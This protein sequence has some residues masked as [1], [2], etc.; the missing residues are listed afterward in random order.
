MFL[1]DQDCSFVYFI[2]AIEKSKRAQKIKADRKT[3]KATRKLYSKK[4][5]EKDPAAIAKAL[6]TIVFSLAALNKSLVADGQEPECH[7]ATEEKALS[8]T[9][10]DSDDDDDTP[11]DPEPEPD[12]PPAPDA[13]DV[14]DVPVDT[15]AD[16]VGDLASAAAAAAEKD[17]DK[18][19]KPP[20]PNSV[21][22]QLNTPLTADETE[23]L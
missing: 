18:K 20:P 4:L 3:L 19:G 17:A 6:E 12:A 9:D 16:V 7:T 21:L 14:P 5:K 13:P 10:S 2:R 15:P 1:S 23:D 22:E 11:S 8:T